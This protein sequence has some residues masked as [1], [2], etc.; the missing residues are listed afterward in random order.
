MNLLT[1]ASLLALAKSI[2]YIYLFINLD[3]SPRGLDY[4]Q[5]KPH[6]EFQKK[7]SRRK[8]VIKLTRMTIL[9]KGQKNGWKCKNRIGE[10]V[11]KKINNTYDRAS[12]S[13]ADSCGT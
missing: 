5:S 6:Y 3:L 12:Y 13:M 8:L 7:K 9:K 10:D 4:S 2:Y 1:G 11:D